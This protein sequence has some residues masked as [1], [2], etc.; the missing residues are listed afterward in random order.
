LTS[1]SSDSAVVIFTP[2]AGDADTL[3]VIV[4]KEGVAAF[5][6]GDAISF[7]TALVDST[8]AI[9]IT[10][11]GLAA[12]SLQ[13]LSA[14]VREQRGWSDIPILVLAGVDSR[15]I[16]SERFDRLAQVGNVILLTRP[17]T[18]LALKMAVRSALRTRRLQFAVRDQLQ[19]LALYSDQLE[20]TIAE[21]T[22]LLEQEVAE[23]RRVEHAL[24]EARRL[25]SL[26]QLTGGIAHDFNNLLQVISGSETLLRMALSTSADLRVT[27]AL[28][29]IRRATGHGASLT[30]QL[31]AYAR[32]QPLTNVLVDLNAHLQLTF[33]MIQRSLGPNI[34]IKRVIDSTIW[35]VLVDPTQLDAAL[36]NVAANARDAMPAGGTL[37]LKACNWQLPDA[38]LPEA[39]HLQ[40]EYVNLSLTDNGEGMSDDTMQQAFEPFFTT[41]EVGKGTGLGLSQVYGFAIQ[42]HGLAFIRRETIGTTV[43]L[44]LPRSFGELPSFTSQPTLNRIGL[45]GQHI[46]CVEDDVD[47]AEST[48]AIL[49]AM[50]ATVKL[51]TSADEAIA[52]Q[53][54]DIDVVFSDVMMPGQM[55]GIDLA[56]WIAANCPDLPIVLTSGYMVSPE[57]LQGLNVQLVR[58]PFTTNMVREALLKSLNRQSEIS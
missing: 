12:C 58:K 40:G 5:V 27:R 4:E 31:L 16:D 30:Q 11:E 14:A 25:E 48:V 43:G 57:R 46:L 24:A 9:V 38:R 39:A 53:L 6:C 8:L 17:M 20:S 13:E 15:G 34:T 28:D 37:T 36:L 55:D 22:R 49:Q 21:R 47:V 26:G 42:S 2:L 33:E 3:R 51:V 18:R 1:Q 56:R 35:S 41:K 23:R 45:E 7:Y 44:L 29:G 10:E 52:T 50:G 54:V 32:K 19:E